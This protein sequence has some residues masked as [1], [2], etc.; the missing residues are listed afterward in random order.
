M[1]YARFCEIV[2]LQS[3]LVVDPSKQDTLDKLVSALLTPNSAV[4]MFALADRF[5]RSHRC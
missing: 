3:E 4:R 2:L 5:F 1:I